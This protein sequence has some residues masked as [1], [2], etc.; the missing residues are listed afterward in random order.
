MPT[1]VNARLYNSA[2]M[3]ADALFAKH[4]AYKS[5]WVVKRYKS[6]GGTYREDG[7]P[8]GLTKWF[9]DKWVDVS[10]PIMHKGKIVGYMP[11]GR[12]DASKGDYPYCR[13]LS[14]AKKMTPSS[15]KKAIA[16]KRTKMNA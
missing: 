6:L 14:V 16:A 4:G 2:K 12:N 3:E 1:P 9:K 8:R 10:R 13:P 15:V 7:K 5:A 11:C